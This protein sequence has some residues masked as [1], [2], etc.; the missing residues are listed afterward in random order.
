M[1]EFDRRIRENLLAVTPDWQAR[2]TGIREEVKSMYEE[3]RKRAAMWTWIGSGIGICIMFLGVG[4]LIF[5]VLAGDVLVAIVGAMM[6]LFGDGWISGS[7]LLYWT[8]NTRLQLE[9]DIKEVHAAVLDVLDRLEHIE[10]AGK[11]ST[12]SE[13]Q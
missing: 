3:R 2:A 13:A 8:W 6:F 10:R 9:R 4:G 11:G 5:G 12:V 1:D 7:K